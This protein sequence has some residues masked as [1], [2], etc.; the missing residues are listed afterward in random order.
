MSD[1]P[2]R[3]VNGVAKVLG[4]LSARL[5]P[6]VSELMYDQE[7]GICTK[8]LQSERNYPQTAVCAWRLPVMCFSIMLMSFLQPTAAVFTS[9]YSATTHSLRASA[10]NTSTPLLECIQVSPPVLSPDT[11]QQTLMVH[12]FGFSYGL[13]F[14]AEYAPP[15]CEFNRVTINFTVTSA[16]RQFDR[17]GHAWFNDTEIFRTS[18][19]EPTQNGIV[20]TYT[21]D[22]SNYL[23]LFKEP[24]KLI[25]DLGNIVDDTY[26][27]SWYTTL[28]A[29]FFTAEDLSPADVIVPVSTRNS[30]SDQPSQF[31]IPEVQAVSALTLP[32][33][34]KKAIF[35]ISASGQATEEFWW[36]NVLSTDTNVFGNDTTLYGYSPFRELQLHI[37]N[38]LAGVAWPFPVIFTGGIVPGFWRPIV[39]IDAFDLLEDEIDITPFL[40]LLCDGKEHTFEIKVVGIDNADGGSGKL[41]SSVGSNWVVS[42]KVFIWLDSAGSITKGTAPTISAPD[43]RLNVSSNVDRSSNGSVKTLDYS[44]TASRT[45][46]LTSNVETSEGSKSATWSQDLQFWLN[47]QLSNGGNDQSTSQSTTGKSNSSNAYS[48]VYDYPLWVISSYNVLPDT[49]Y[50]IDAKMGRGKYV[51]QLGSLAFPN[52]DQTFDF[53]SHQ[54][55]DLFIGTHTNNWQNGT[56]HYLGSPALKKSFGSGSTEQLFSLDG[57]VDL[58]NSGVDLYRRHTIAVNDSVTYDQEIVGDSMQASQAPLAAAPSLEKQLFAGL[59]IK[60][61]LGR[62]PF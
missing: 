35:S 43:P 53:S 49:N 62:G 27:G 52:S 9:Q 26:T 61:A 28:T 57:I 40:P 23:S 14:V 39:G 31:V 38:T 21:K 6:R 60:A 48:R 13:P 44:V 46:S 19:A 55:P 11:C 34:I 50:T 16:G 56:A 20:W 4:S 45:F 24:Q 22:M 29:N 58:A 47:G 7:Q 36:A 59:S 54:N 25:F 2:L 1:I 17:L 41:S 42:G 3:G 10:P 15:A 12:T 18:T 37:D 51:Q 8:W 32:Q 33:N 30:G 5:T